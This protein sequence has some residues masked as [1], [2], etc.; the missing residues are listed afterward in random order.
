MTDQHARHIELPGTYNLRDTGGYA[1]ADGRVTRWNTLLRSDSLHA[2]SPA[3]RRVLLDRG[4][5]TI[6]DLRRPAEVQRDP[7]VFAGLDEARYHNIPV[8]DDSTAARVDHQ[9][10]DLD[11]LYRNYVDDCQGAF[12][13][14]L[15][16][17]AHAESGP[18]LVHCMVGKD[19]TGVS[20]ALA[21]GAAGVPDETIIADYAPSAA[22]L[23]PLLNEWR[24]ELVERGASTARFDE[25]TQ[26]PPAAMA[27]LLQHL[28]QRYDGVNGYLRTIGVTA[29]E[30]AAIR[31]KLTT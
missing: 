6:I 10:Q 3:G 13:D 22:N 24:Q 28:R 29:A 1:T 26:S 23:R 7:N 25:V 4:I 17:I 18:V 31:D 21:L 19:R 11:E 8:F 30:I 5:Q 2:L 16:V 9:A 20:V 27:N 12:R 14:V 15:K